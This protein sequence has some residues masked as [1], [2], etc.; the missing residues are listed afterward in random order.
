MG[1]INRRENKT[2]TAADRSDS[3]LDDRTTNVHAL[4]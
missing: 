2:G 1:T 3:N 4:L